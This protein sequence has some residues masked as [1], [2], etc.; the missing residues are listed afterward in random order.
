[1]TNITVVISKD[2]KEIKLTVKELQDLHAQIEVM[3][4]VYKKVESPEEDEGW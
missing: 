3:S 1:M 2:G 4:N